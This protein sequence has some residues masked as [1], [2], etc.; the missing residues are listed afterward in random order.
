MGTAVNGVILPKIS[1]RLADCLPHRAGE[2]QGP[3][4]LRI[5]AGHK[6]A[7]HGVKRDGVDLLSNADVLQQSVRGPIF[8][9]FL[10]LPGS[11]QQ[12]LDGDACIQMAQAVADVQIHFVKEIRDLVQFTLHILFG[13]VQHHV[14][15]YHPIKQCEYNAEHDNGHNAEKQDL[16]PDFQVGKA[17][18]HT[19]HVNHLLRTAEGRGQNLTS[20]PSGILKSL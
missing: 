18:P 16:L 2:M 17:Q 20:A 3:V 10:A 5:I 8:V 9:R 15:N 14:G 4:G 11:S 13:P 1:L 19:T 6:P 12:L 7:V